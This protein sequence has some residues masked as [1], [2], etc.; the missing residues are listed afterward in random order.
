MGLA[1]PASVS[2]AT[3][4]SLTAFDG[5]IG[6]QNGAPA[7]Q[8]GSH[9]FL[10][11]TS[12][13]F[14]TFVTAEEREWPAGSLKD[15]EV[16]LPAGLVANPEAYPTCTELELVGS[17]GS[18]GCPASSQVGTLIFR[19][20]GGS[21]P[22]NQVG[23]LYNMERPEGATAVLGANV[24]SSL[25]HLVT[26]LRTGDDYGIRIVARNT[27]QTVVILG[28]TVVLWGT[29][30]SPSFDSQRRPP[31]P[32]KAPLRPF[33]TLPTSCLGP[34]R[35]DLRVTSWEGEADSAFF[36][37]HD[38][39]TPV[40][41]PIGTTGCNTL[42]FSPTLEAR[43]TANVADSPSGF[44][45]HL[46]IPPGDVDDPAGTVAAH[47]RDAVVALPEGVAVNAAG[48][49]GLRG[50]S[51]A[52]IGLLSAVGAIPIAY[53]EDAAR[54]PD[55]A[56]LGSVEAETPL[57]DHPLRG[58]VH[59]ATPYD[60]PFGSLLAF[61]VTVADRESGI[62][63]KLA[64]RVQA[65]PVTGRLTVGFAD[66]PQLPFEDLALR[67]FDGPDA[68]LRT[69]P[70]C[71]VYES[72]ST[73]TPWSAP[74]SGP[75]ATPGD[76][77]AI[78]RSPDG[79]AC[80][81]SPA[82]QPNAPTFEAGAISPLAGAPSSFIAD[83]RRADGSQ[84]FSSLALTAPAGLAAKLVGIPSCSD[85][86]LA[87][88]ETRAGWEEEAAPSC[89]PAS[90]VGTVTVAA[91]AG[92]TPYYLPGKA[93]LADPYKGA[94]FSVA[95]VVPAT[96]GPFDLGTIVVRAALRVDPRTARITIEADPF[97]TILQGIPLD[98][99]QVRLQ[100]DRPGFT[101]NP[102]SCDPTSVTGSLR[103][104]LGEEAPLSSRFQVGECGRLGFAPHLA[105]RL[106]GPAHRGAH[107]RLRAVAAA[108]SGDANLRR[109]ALTLPGTQLLESRQIRD[110]CGREAFAARGCP[111]ESVVGSAT[112]W[113]PLLADPLHGPL[114]L[115]AS[116]GELPE[117]V[118]ALDGRVRIDLPARVD[119]Q[120]G[121]LRIAFQALPDIPL[122]RL[123]LTTFGGRRSLFANT[124]GICT[125]AP[126][127]DASL[128]AHNGRTLSLRPRLRADC[129]R[130]LR[131]RP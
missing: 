50:C 64:G 115:R 23:G 129:R 11:S 60:N 104:T 21:T 15:A 4:F 19:S 86:A 119:T 6:L 114:V 67:F 45:V 88:A 108:R 56:K 90:Q 95:I 109:L 124:S 82:D 128:L 5:F 127:A 13:S 74:D 80:P 87:A 10:A 36:L 65:D 116:R 73:L 122:K 58:S 62:V 112:A 121:R 97:P 42:E 33:L 35:T 70:T 8:A 51:A 85:P 46:H 111:P 96:A 52:D 24:S 92:P 34:L 81:S 41:N 27:P 32:S 29:P 38:D 25:V 16:D 106:L 120:A 26:G 131:D 101:L 94:P 49:N 66:F 55:A 98:V 40:P 75:P 103:S 2:A 17:G 37:S 28:G 77:F 9:P 12:F 43:P 126:R 1:W 68:L 44:D 100:L 118:A 113:S 20:G 53:T 89:P 125:R 78:E 105:L 110:V 84:R 3:P 59:L 79:A 83:L 61:Y 117:L 72:A 91:G 57:L 31:G 48:A 102:T 76:A 14:S 63:V 22:F 39:T 7:T 107:P 130:P 30:A 69:P 93:Y 18:A 47:L 123:V 99:R 71:G 54:C